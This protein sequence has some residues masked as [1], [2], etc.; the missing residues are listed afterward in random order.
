MTSCLVLLFIKFMKFFF[1][2]SDFC[3]KKMCLSLSQLFV[4]F[5]IFP[6]KFCPREFRLV[7]KT[8]FVLLFVCKSPIP[9]FHRIL[10]WIIGSIFPLSGFVNWIINQEAYWF[11][12]VSMKNAF[13]LISHREAPYI[14]D[15]NYR[16]TNFSIKFPSIESETHFS[17]SFLFT[18]LHFPIQFISFGK[19]SAFEI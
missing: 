5:V 7:H 18:T 14:N 10:F 12:F 13:I 4:R 6:G 15:S 16:K 9:F 2:R 17:I 19:W 8:Y 1:I 11:R 3:K